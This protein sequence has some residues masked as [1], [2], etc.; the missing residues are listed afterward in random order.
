MPRS[1]EDCLF[2][3]PP[4][5]EKNFKIDTEIL[6]K[7]GVNHFLTPSELGLLPG[8]RIY[9]QDMGETPYNYHF[10][11][12][13]GRAGSLESCTAVPEYRMKG[14]RPVLVRELFIRDRIHCC[15]LLSSL[16]VTPIMTIPLRVTI[17]PGVE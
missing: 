12:P 17:V 5:G 11:Y 6:E 14:E 3:K 2:G 7:A 9:M 15:N 4:V 16:V 1:R 8:T 10:K 13:D